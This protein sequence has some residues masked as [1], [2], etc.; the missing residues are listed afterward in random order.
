MKDEATVLKREKSEKQWDLS[1][2]IIDIWSWQ[3]SLRVSSA[4]IEMTNVRS[5]EATLRDY[6]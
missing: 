4:R 6:G 5:L 1:N 2:I 3:R